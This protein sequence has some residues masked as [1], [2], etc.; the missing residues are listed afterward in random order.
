MSTIRG[1]WEEDHDRTQRFFNNE[2][3]QWGGAPYLC[4]AWVNETIVVQ[5]L[6]S[7][8]NVEHFQLQI[9][10]VA[11]EKFVVPILTKKE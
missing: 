8:A 11:T 9:Y 3:G 1:W 10:S 6:H 2:L 5:H 7:P 4:D